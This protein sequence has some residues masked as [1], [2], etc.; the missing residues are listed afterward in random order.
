MFIANGQQFVHALVSLA[1]YCIILYPSRTYILTFWSCNFIAT[2]RNLSCSLLFFLALMPGE[3]SDS[4]C[5]L[6]D[7]ACAPFSM[8]L[9]ADKAEE[10]PGLDM[11][12]GDPV[13]P[14]VP[15]SS[16]DGE[17]EVPLGSDSCQGASTFTAKKKKGELCN[18]IGQGGSLTRLHSGDKNLE[19]LRRPKETVLCTIS[20]PRIFFVSKLPPINFLL[21]CFQCG[22]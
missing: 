1:L 12:G 2:K 22:S 13:L 21:Y 17:Q 20:I 18:A 7:C 19:I 9:C 5:R 15:G 11:Y 10:D 4:V 3:H 8:A 14:P 16:S 6:S